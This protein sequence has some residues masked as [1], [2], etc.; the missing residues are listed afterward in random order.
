MFYKQG[1][2]QN[3]DVITYRCTVF[4][5]EALDNTAVL[6]FE[7]YFNTQLQTGPRGLVS[8]LLHKVNNTPRAVTRALGPLGEVGHTTLHGKETLQDIF[9]LKH[10]FECCLLTLGLRHEGCITAGLAPKCMNDLILLM[11][12]SV[13][14]T[15]TG[16]REF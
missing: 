12:E 4:I 2:P 14:I 1:H 7:C 9:G 8:P 15:F 11:A 5:S 13:H 10:P 16:I 6:S 3:S